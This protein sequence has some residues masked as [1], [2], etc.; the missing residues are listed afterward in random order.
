MLNRRALVPFA[1]AVLAACGGPEPP[2]PGPVL[3]AFTHEIIDPSPN[4]GD[5]CC[6]DV[7]AIGDLSGDGLPDVVLGAERAPKDGLVWYRAPRFDRF[8]IASGQFT[9][10]GKVADMNGDGR[11]DVITCDHGED[12]NDIL[13]FENP[14]PAGGPWTRHLVGH[15]YAHDLEVADLDGNGRPDLVTCDKEEVDSWWQQPDGSFSFRKLCDD[16]GE[17]IDC[18]DIDGDG[19]IDVAFGASW[20]R[21]PDADD[22][23][24]QRVV[25]SPPWPQDTRVR[26]AD[27]DGDGRVDLVL[28]VSEGSGRVAW[29][30]APKDPLIAPWPAHIVE[31]EQLEGAHS[32]QVADVD[33]DGDPDLVVAEMHTSPERRVMVYY[34][35]APD[36]WRR[37]ILA[38]TGSHNMRVADLDAD[39]DPDLVG[40]NYGGVGR[41]LEAWRNHIAD[42]RPW[43][44]IQI[45][46]DRP[47]VDEGKTGLCFA[48]IDRDGRVD[49]VSGGHWWRNPGGDLSG[50]W[51]R[52][53]VD[54]EADLHFAV[55]IDHDAHQD[56]LGFVT[57]RLVWYEA[58]D[59]GGFTKTVVSAPLP[60]G[61][62]QGGA[63]GQL[64]AGGREEVVFTRGKHL[65][66]V[67]LPDDPTATPWNIVRLSD[68]TEEEG[69]AMG[70]V[71]RDGDQ[72]V[73]AVDKKGHHVLWFENPGGDGRG[74]WSYKEIGG[75]RA[76]LDRVAL[77]D[78]DHDGRLDV[79]ATTESQDWE[80]N[81]DLLVWNGPED[82]H[83]EWHGRSVLRMRSINSLGVGDVD[84]DGWPDLAI[85]EHTDQGG[86]TAAPDTITAVLL[87]R[88]GGAR[89]EVE[90]VD[91]SQRS[92]HL[93]AQ[94]IDL[95]GDGDLD[96][97]STAWAQPQIHL[98][99]ND[100]PRH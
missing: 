68:H 72:D 69:V 4:T 98:W 6:T 38:R 30:Q 50:A 35:D 14:G 2:P 1:L 20:L 22:Q 18:G 16:E 12:A 56:L 40:K 21:N 77:V 3:T 44:A 64:V 96:L 62:T 55:D 71:D 66:Y 97:V 11:A 63:I 53:E 54:A 79:V 42:P 60:E 9:T 86:R 34:Q 23:P 80:P 13:W 85:G 51:Q 19:H 49:V 24:W 94:L 31:K 70:D 29:F 61:R 90:Y 59:G 93:G 99:R 75:S 74:S 33:L 67:T 47:K 43:T 95:D 15:G 32:L 81:T 91:I 7:L 45:E 5:D 37:V 82:P 8:P 46:P 39:G 84:G 78:L 58:K 28:T 65:F 10:D 100:H 92:N 26:I 87:D 52:T 48:D 89:F 73:V 17:G 41:K 83:G 88:D 76:W 36:T 57:D 27:I 25:V